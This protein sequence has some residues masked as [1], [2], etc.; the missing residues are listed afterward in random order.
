MAAKPLNRTAAT[1]LSK[2]L[3]M[4]GNGSSNGLSQGRKTITTAMFC[5]D[6]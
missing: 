3:G 5:T 2:L 1:F 6:I 4:V